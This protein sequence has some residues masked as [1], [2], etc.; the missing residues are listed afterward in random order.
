MA[1]DEKVRANMA[2][3]HLPDGMFEEAR[4]YTDKV[5]NQG[6]YAKNFLFEYALA[7]VVGVFCC[8][9]TR[10]SNRAYH[11]DLRLNHTGGMITLPEFLYY[12]VW[13]FK[14]LA[15]FNYAGMTHPLYEGTK[16][17]ENLAG[18]LE[19]IFAAKGEPRWRQK[20]CHIEE[21]DYSAALRRVLHDGVGIPIILEIT[22][23]LSMYGFNCL[24]AYVKA[25]AVGMA[26]P[27]EEAWYL[28]NGEYGARAQPI[29]P[30]E[31]YK[32]RTWYCMGQRGSITM[33]PLVN[34]RQRLERITQC[35]ADRDDGMTAAARATRI[36]GHMTGVLPQCIPRELMPRDLL[37][38]KGKGKGKGIPA[39]MPP[40]TEF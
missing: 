30:P 27:E 33:T 14:A 38:V 9:S 19:V 35:I 23:G 21:G 37:A 2:E 34:I 3:W 40:P 8:C 29:D 1:S 4:E 36:L 39:L 22:V 13:F 24:D 15:L 11:A 6:M 12:D 5:A 28:L 31:W 7:G 17:D 25:L 26:S 18:I 16:L 10:E 32:C 20:Y